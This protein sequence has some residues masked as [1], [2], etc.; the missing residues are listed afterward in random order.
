MFR[1]LKSTVS[2]QFFDLFSKTES[3]TAVIL[4]MAEDITNR[5]IFIVPTEYRAFRNVSS[6]KPNLPTKE[7]EQRE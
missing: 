1:W 2:D 7:K 4:L 3:L 5:I 6:Q